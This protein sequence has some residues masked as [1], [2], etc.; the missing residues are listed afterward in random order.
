[1]LL[2]NRPISLIFRIVFSCKISEKI[3][4]KKPL[5]GSKTNLNQTLAKT[6]IFGH[7]LQIILKLITEKPI[8]I[9]EIIHVNLLNSVM[10][11]KSPRNF[12]KLSIF[13]ISKL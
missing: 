12:I 10:H 9:S 3:E 2:T 11:A 1:M 13:L 7:V 6:L 5:A 4:R 8:S